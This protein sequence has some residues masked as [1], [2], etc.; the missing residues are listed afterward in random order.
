MSQLL[1]F[2]YGSQSV[3]SDNIQ[4]VMYVMILQSGQVKVSI[5]AIDKARIYFTHRL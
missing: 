1:G 3:I 4:C 2:T 5:Y